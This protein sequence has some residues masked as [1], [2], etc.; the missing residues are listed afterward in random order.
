[1]SEEVTRPT[2]P[3]AG[4]VQFLANTADYREGKEGTVYGAGHITTYEA[5]D[6]DFI[7]GCYLE[8]RI[9][10]VE[11]L[12]PPIELSQPT[13]YVPKAQPKQEQQTGQKK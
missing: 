6:L 2:L 7:K 5:A 3:D 11:P 12:P 4:K 9:A 8:G 1:V 10:L 13:N